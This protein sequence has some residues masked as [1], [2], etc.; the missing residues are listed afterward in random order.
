MI[1]DSLTPEGLFRICDKACKKKVSVYQFKQTLKE[2]N[3]GMNDEQIQR[4][5]LIFD[6][7]YNEEIT[8][9][10]YIDTLDAFGALSEEDYAR[11]PD[12]KRVSVAKRAMF[13]VI[14]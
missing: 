9:P 11:G 3:A 12:E 13:K 8:Y 6:E 10:E 14:D 2:M 1:K 5:V 4:L 7:D